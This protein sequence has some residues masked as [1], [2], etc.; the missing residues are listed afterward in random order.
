MIFVPT[1]K[2]GEELRQALQQ[3][4]I[5]LPFF[6]AGAWTATER[7]MVMKRFTGSLEPPINAVICTNAF[8]MGIDVPNVRL[9]VHWQHPAS[10]ED[11]VQEFGRAGRDGK[12]AAAVLLCEESAEWEVGLLK[13]MA[14][15]TIESSTLSGSAA[16]DALE[17]RKQQIAQMSAVARRDSRCFRRQLTDALGNETPTRHSLAVRILERIFA[18][19]QR[20][21]RAAVCCD[22]C[23]RQAAS[24]ILRGDLSALSSSRRS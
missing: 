12:P 17:G 8:G 7:E 20:A 10:V 5:T 4:G 16:S 2:K 18:H 15:K 3:Q 24:R 9:V 19:Q 22:A 6:H 21:T 14:E 23:N 13:F 11:Y 1:K